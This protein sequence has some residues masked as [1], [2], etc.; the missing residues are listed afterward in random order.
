MKKA[1]IAILVVFIGFWMFQDPHGLAV[2][3]QDV[4]GQLVTWTGDL[5]S[6]VINFVG[7]L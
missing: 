7:E 6:A 2:T 3:T 5:F 4:A 1:I